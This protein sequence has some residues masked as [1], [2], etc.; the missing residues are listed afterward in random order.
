MGTLFLPFLL[1]IFIQ[2]KSNILLL[3][4]PSIVQKKGKIKKGPWIKMGVS[5]I[6]PDKIGQIK[7]ICVN[8]DKMLLKKG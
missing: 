3:Y 7:R 1:K 2:L 4:P 8:F 6:G 5:K